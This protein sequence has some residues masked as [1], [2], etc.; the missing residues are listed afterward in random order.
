MAQV[1]VPPAQLP[2]TLAMLK[3]HLRIDSVDDDDLL[4]EYLSAATT[5]AES[6]TGRAL[7]T[8]TIQETFRRAY[9]EVELTR[10]PVQTIKSVM[11][12]GVPVL[13]YSF[14]PGDDAVVS[15]LPK[16]DVVATYIAGY[17]DAGTLVPAPIKQWIMAATGAF[18]ENREAEIADSRAATVVLTYLDCLLDGYRIWRA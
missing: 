7:I 12:A 1:I 3:K 16:G 6:I 9:G 4:T 2:V 15:G 17:D 10:W 11:V 8:Q 13:S 18:N 14:T 5:R